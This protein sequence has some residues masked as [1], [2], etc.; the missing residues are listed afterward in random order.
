MP[1]R[2]AHTDLDL[3]LGWRHGD[4]QMG[5]ELY[6]RYKTPV[7]NLFRRNV[8]SKHDI[9]DLV[10]QTFLACVHAK[11]DPEIA[12]TVRGYI[13]GIAFHT[14]TGF[15]RRARPA[16][17]LDLTGEQ[18]TALASI[19]PDPEYLLTLG[20]E[21][22]LLMKAI[23]RIP[24]EYQVIIELNYWEGVPCNQIAEILR[25]PQGTVRSR[26]QRGRA[27]LEKTLAALADSPE[28]LAATTMSMSAWQQGI[29]AWITAQAGQDD[30][31]D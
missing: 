15:F 9:P 23:R 6:D 13:L 29:H 17:A 30:P 26:L 18:G 11:N 5:A 7:T 24:M 12:G 10:Q 19:E 21:Q 8:Q 31:A 22:R 4:T 3:L 25:I 14:M 2:S 28:L 27:A 16:L 1:I 20:D